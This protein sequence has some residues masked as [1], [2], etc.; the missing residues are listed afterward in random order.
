MQPAPREFVR[1]SMLEEEHH[2]MLRTRR[3]RAAMR[4][5]GLDKLGRHMKR[6]AA[7]ASIYAG[8]VGVYGG[9]GSPRRDNGAT[10]RH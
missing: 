9:R 6:G 1:T 4:K 7:S 2:A 8:A 3:G 5:D 10:F